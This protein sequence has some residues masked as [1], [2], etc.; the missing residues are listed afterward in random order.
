MPN[1]PTESEQWFDEYLDLN[2]YT[3]QREPPLAVMKKPDRLIDRA[4]I[5]AICEI[6]E[7]RADP[8]TRRWPRGG[9][10]VGSF[11]AAD[12]FL[13][14]RRRISNAAEQLEPLSGQ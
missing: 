4:G 10:R 13:D 1:A 6:K 3:Y 14:V 7:F 8:M 9:R 2:G 11:S 5:E 12:W